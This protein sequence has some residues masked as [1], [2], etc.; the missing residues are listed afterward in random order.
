MTLCR[1]AWGGELLGEAGLS[2][3]DLQ[4]HLAALPGGIR[5]VFEATARQVIELRS[6]LETYAA[7]LQGR[8]RATH[9]GDMVARLLGLPLERG[10]EAIPPMPTT[11]QRVPPA[12]IGGIRLLPGYEFPSEPATLRLRG[13]AREEETI[14]VGR[15]FGIAQFQ[16]GASVY[17]RGIR[18]RVSGLDRSS[19]WNPRSQ[20]P[21]G[22]TASAGAAVCVSTVG[23]HDAPAVMATRS[24]WSTQPSTSEG[25]SACGTSGPSW[26]RR[27]DT[28][29]GI[30]SR[31]NRSGTANHQ[32]LGHPGRL[33]PAPPP[34][35]NDPLAE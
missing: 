17:A 26:M 8:F 18:W 23:S 5:R 11:A 25:S 19:P 27:S 30:W 22:D 14:S 35:R 12:P 9:A 33:E 28:P 21:R 6:P 2:V 13:D 4:A 3:Q 34:R 16:P 29:R 32:A 7:N 10:S 24:R 15:R 1:E 31:S 20:N